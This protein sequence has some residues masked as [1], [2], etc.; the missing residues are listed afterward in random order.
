MPGK[1]TDVAVWWEYRVML[2]SGMRSGLRLAVSAI[3]WVLVVLPMTS[4][5]GSHNPT[6]LLDEGLDLYDDKRFLNAEAALLELLKSSSFRKLDTSQRSLVYSHIAYSKINRGKD[7]ESIQYLDKALAETKREFGERSIPYLRHMRTKAVALYWTNNQR[8]AKRVAE[9]ILEHLSR[10]EGDYRDEQQNIRF[11]ISEMRKV[12]LE[13]DELPLD[14][15]EFYTDCE[16]ID[17]EK[18]LT[19]VDSIMNDYEQI[20]RDIRPD[21]KQAQYFKNTYITHARESSTDRRKRIIYV[22]DD[23]HMDDWCVIYPDKAHIDRVIISAS[24]DR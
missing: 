11:M 22:P 6:K 2:F 18:Y 14:L 1:L 8:K 15:S 19:R 7:K 12:N 13:R 5:A 20:G 21:R 17:G 4:F 10:M 23:E 3:I 16:S 24:N 9:R